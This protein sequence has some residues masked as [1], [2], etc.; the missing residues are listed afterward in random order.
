MVEPSMKQYPFSKAEIERSIP[1]RFERIV[2][3]YPWRTAIRSERGS[4]TYSE[5][6]SL[7]NRVAQV[8]MAEI[9]AS[10]APITLLFGHEPDIIPALLGVLKSGNP[11]AALDPD[12]P[13]ARNSFIVEDLQTSLIITNTGHQSLAEEL[14][15][16]NFQVLNVDHLDS[17]LPEHNPTVQPISPQSLEGIFYTSGTTGEPKGVVR[18]HRCLLHRIWLESND[19]AINPEDNISLIHSSSFGA[20]QTDIFN[21]LLNGATLSL[22]DLKKQGLDRLVPWLKSEEI[23][24]FHVPSDLFRQFIELLKED[25]AFPKLRQVTPSGRLFSMDVDRIRKH[26][27]EDCVLIQRLASTETGMIT[28]FIINKNTE[29]RG[30]VIPVGYAVQDSEVLILDE[31]GDKLQPNNVGEI[32]VRSSYLATGYWRRPEMTAAAFL[33]VPGESDKKMYRLGDLGRMRSDGCVELIG[34]KDS[35]VKIRGYR[36]ELGEIEAALLSLEEILEVFVITQERHGGEKRLVAYVVPSN[37]GKVSNKN[38]RRSLNEK[39]P[40]YMIPS[41]FIT[42]DKLPLTDRKKIALDALPD[43]GWGRPELDEEFIPPRTSIEVSLAEIWSEILFVVPVGISDNFFELGGHSL[44]AAQITA[45]TNTTFKTDLPM[46]ALFDAPTIS[47]FAAAV[48]I[49]ARKE[50]DL[51]RGNLEKSIKLLGY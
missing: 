50:S 40:E 51:E 29:L 14:S 3:Q 7:A 6:N 23:T 34:R 27:P 39:L 36:V 32:A 30:N 17:N 19:Y 2:E 21:A 48:E 5:L 16:K 42:L 31:S 38:L 35:Q 37:H 8:I 47:E 33:P 41:I 20:S 18:S 24:F 28:R 43:P 15:G 10:L 9:G 49:A 22:F 11:Y 25:D 13:A 46:R 4:I 1:E 45:R 44:L 26:I 12:I